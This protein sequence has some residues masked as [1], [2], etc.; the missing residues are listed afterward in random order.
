[1]FIRRCSLADR[2][3]DVVRVSLRN[4]VPD[5]PGSSADVAAG[6]ML[7]SKL[8]A[9]LPKRLVCCVPV[10]AQGVFSDGGVGVAWDGVVTLG[11]QLNDQGAWA[12]LERG[13]HR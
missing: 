10:D 9:M 6:L 1:V 12:L 11:L 3:D 8:Q 13:P 4:F 5:E 7:A 2:Y